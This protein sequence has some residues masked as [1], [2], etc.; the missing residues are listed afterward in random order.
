YIGDS[1]F[2]ADPENN[3][4]K[5]WI[6]V[7]IATPYSQALSRPSIIIRQSENPTLFQSMVENFRKIVQ[8]SERPPAQYR[9]NNERTQA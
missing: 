9:Q 5:G 3:K 2:I 8:N 7:D 1:L 4:G 6:R